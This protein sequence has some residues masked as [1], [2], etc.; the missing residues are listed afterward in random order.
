MVEDPLSSRRGFIGGVAAFAACG[1]AIPSA[2]AKPMSKGVTRGIILSGRDL[3]GR[4]NWPKIAAEA[5]L[6]TIGTH[7]GPSDVLPFMRS[8]R[9]KRF[10]DECAKHGIAVEHELHAMND[11][12]PRKYFADRPE[13]FRMNDKGERAPD[14]NCCVSNP[15]AIEIVCA[16]AVKV[17]KEIPSSTGRYFFWLADGS[18]RCL[19]PKCTV[20]SGVDQAVILENAIVNALRADVDPNA[21]LAHLS[22]DDKPTSSWFAPPHFTK[23]DP[24]LFLEFA[25][26]DRWHGKN[27][28]V[29]LKDLPA[30]L[31]NLD[32]L[33]KVFPASTAQVLEYWL[34][35]SFFSYR[36]RP[37]KAIPWNAQQAQADL[38]EYIRRGIRHVTTFAV[39]MDDEYAAVVG[40]GAF[41]CVR[42]YGSMLKRVI[43]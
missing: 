5:G 26:F 25:P 9:G 17:A 6:T 3:S 11:L 32:K 39:D 8:G 10:V 27:M 38:A 33:L 28:G 2:A 19:C 24:A 16:N 21:T 23:P 35:E 15:T 34:D 12:L 36:H 42:E 4:L 22:Y 14:Y 43:N 29:P 41:D 30:C 7:V 13:L 20:L 31:A 37:R 40:P 18:N 1:M